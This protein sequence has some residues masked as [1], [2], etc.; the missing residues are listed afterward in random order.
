MP[1][2]SALVAQT[3]FNIKECRDHRSSTHSRGLGGMSVGRIF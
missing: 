1:L 3:T 2:Q